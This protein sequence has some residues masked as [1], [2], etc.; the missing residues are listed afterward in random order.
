M[1]VQ[2]KDY[3]QTLGVAKSAGQDEIQK[4][5]RKLARKYHPDVA[6]DKSTAE[7]KFKEINEAY[8]VLRDPAKRQKYDA[9]GADWDKVQP[10]PPGPGGMGG[11]PGGQEFSGG[12]Y[13]FHFGGTGFS[14]FFEAFFG[15]GGMGGGGGY[16][17]GNRTGYRRRN[18]ARRGRDVEGDIMVTLEEALKGSTRGVSFQRSNSSATETYQV[19]IP[20]GVREGQRIRLSGQGEQ[21]AGGAQSGDLYLRVRLASH[22]D[23]RVEGNDLV[24]ELTVPISHLVLGGPVEVP[25]VEGTRMRLK[26]PAGTQPGQKFRMRGHG[27]P[28]GPGRPRGDL[29]VLV[30]A[31]VPK[32]L[33]ES[34]RKLWEELA[35]VER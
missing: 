3:Y 28:T 14:D 11:F 27:M 13:E 2:F 12:E 34:E 30:Q 23:F 4:A 18:V 33:S 35:K 22:P 32:T 8:E 5:F 15:S 6:E 29:Y 25:T 9:L 24:Y 19:K 31:S 16:G 10:P 17:P 7:A 20:P 26:I 21:G 1:A